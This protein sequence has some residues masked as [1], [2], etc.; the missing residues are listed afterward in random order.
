MKLSFR[1]AK[2]FDGKLS[3]GLVSL[4]TSRVITNIASG[5]FGVFLP[6]FL[7]D[8]LFNRNITL[9]VLYYLASQALYLI[10]LPVGAR[11]L[12]KFGFR[13]SLQLSTVCG[14]L[15]YLGLRLLT[16][17]TVHIVVPF[18]VIIITIWRILYWVPYHVDFAKFSGKRNRGKTVGLMQSIFSLTGVIAPV[19]AGFIIT[20]FGYDTL[21][22]A[23]VVIYIASLIPYATIPRT[24]EKFAWGYFQTWKKLFKKKHI[25]TTL[26]FVADGAEAVVGMIIWPIFIFLVLKGDYM[27]VGSISSA[28]VLI[29]MTMQLFMG[30]YADKRPKKAMLKIGTV[31]YAIIWIGKIFILTFFHIFLADM[32]HKFS[33]IFLRIPFDAV[34]YEIAADQGH[35]VDEFTVLHEMAVSMGRILMYVSII[36]LVCVF[37]L[38]LKWVF[39]LAAVASLTFNMIYF[40]VTEKKA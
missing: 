25:G 12:N 8:E 35:Y 36:V 23:G 22:V 31:L 24:K 1:K 32:F 11:F 10:F 16:P 4:L 29:T 38:T 3:H 40:E 18:L 34:T 7:Y 2:Y 33:K 39:I 19:A 14:A 28:V 37:S 27:K 26:A 6:I 9:V 30:K 13:H 21:F 5:F 17:D 20:K 15:Y